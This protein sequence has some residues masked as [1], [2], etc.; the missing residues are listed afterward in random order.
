MSRGS[1][2]GYDRHITIFSPEGR[3]FQVGMY[4]NSLTIPSS[5]LNSCS[6]SGF[7][8]LL[9]D[10][11][12]DCGKDYFALLFQMSSTLF[13]VV[14]ESDGRSTGWIEFDP[15]KLIATVVCGMEL[16]LKCPDSLN[17]IVAISSC[18]S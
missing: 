1:G 13:L 8:A 3:L 7:L 2:G 9:I 4:I 17:L 16:N 18:C 14:H 12:S 5:Y 6:R 10:I 11:W 15:G